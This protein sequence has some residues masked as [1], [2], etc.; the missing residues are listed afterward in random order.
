MK[1]KVL[2]RKKRLYREY[3]DFVALDVSVD[4][5]FR[6]M[7]AEA[8][9]DS[10]FEITRGNVPQCGFL[11]DGLVFLAEKVRECPV[12]FD[13]GLV[14]FKFYAKEFP[15]ITAYSGNNLKQTR[16]FT[17]GSSPTAGGYFTCEK[18]NR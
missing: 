11:P 9:Y 1:R 8:P 3:I 16:N 5:D 17:T 13:E 7:L 6:K 15:H 10:A 14:I 4:D 18:E 12:S 2:L